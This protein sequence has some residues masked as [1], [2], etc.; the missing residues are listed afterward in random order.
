[1]IIT[2]LK[3][4]MI[5]IGIDANAH[6]KPWFSDEDNG[7]GNEMLDLIMRNNLALLNKPFQQAS[8]N[9]GTSIDITLCSVNLFDKIQEWT[10]HEGASRKNN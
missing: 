6:P 9:S 7:R 3:G 8:H 5:V 2:E 1:M 10:V 4:Q